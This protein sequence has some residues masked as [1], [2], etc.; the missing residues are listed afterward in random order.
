MFAVEMPSHT[1]LSQKIYQGRAPI[2]ALRIHILLLQRPQKQ[3]D[4]VCKYWM[5]GHCARGNKCWYLHS[6]CRGDGFMMLAKLEGHKKAVHGIALPLGSEK[7]YSGSGDG[8]LR[9]WDCHSGHCAHLSNLGDEVGS[10]IT[11]GLWVF[12]GMKGVIKAWNTQTAQE[13]SLKGPVGHVHS[14]VVSDNMLFAGAQNGFTFAWKSSSEAANPFQLIASMEGHSGA[15][16]CL[17]V[18]DKKL[19]S[20]S[21][22]HTIRVWD[23]DTLQC[24]KTL[25]GHEDAVMSLLHC[26][27]CLFSCSLDCSIKVWFATDGENWEV[28]YTHK[29][30][31]GMLA[32]CGMNDAETKPVLFCSCND[33]TVRLYDLP[34]FTERGRLYSEREVRVIHRGPFPL[35]FTGDGTG[36]VT[37]WKWL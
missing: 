19:Y 1:M 12:V 34:S 15:V 20:G 5:S 27:G 3:E 13:F 6:W 25:N 35:F 16:L 8:T 23:T 22:D 28:I 30:E 37:V 7:L 26:N 36:S 21:V 31:N 11:E 17:A 4:K 29:E 18:R 10:M 33:D 32:L 14:M 2:I 24:I 9:T